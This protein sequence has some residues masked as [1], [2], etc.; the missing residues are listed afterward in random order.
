L[1]FSLVRERN[2]EIV[3]IR[4]DGTKMKVLT[5]HPHM[6]ASPAW[7]PDGRRIAF[8]RWFDRNEG[9][10]IFVMA[11]DGSGLRQ[12]TGRSPL[13]YDLH[14]TWSP[15]G[16]KLAFSRVTRRGPT[17]SSSDD[18][19]QIFRINLDG[20]QEKAL[21]GRKNRRDTPAW[22]PDGEW[23]L[24]G[25]DD[26]NIYRMKP[27]GSRKKRLATA[28]NRIWYSS[29]DWSPDGDRFAFAK[30]IIKSEYSGETKICIMHEDGG[31]HR[32]VV[33][34]GYSPRWSPD[35]RK[36]AF[37]RGRGTIVKKPVAGGTSS[38]V[39]QKQGTVRD[40]SWQPRPHR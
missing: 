23:I 6:D 14:P 7:S 28:T 20:S 3:S 35:G 40:L 37:L 34:S 13:H 5:D 39:F 12:V 24:Y 21:T 19:K 18:P 2:Q 15:D 1:A 16:E 10:A 17:R 30:S 26:F 8:S 36:I 25:S 4:P 22:A 31:T 9:A 38:V 29:P 33:K 11:A 32:C 27:D